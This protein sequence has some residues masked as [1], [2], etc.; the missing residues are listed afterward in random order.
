MSIVKKPF[1]SEFKLELYT[2]SSLCS[3]I[4]TPISTL[5]QQKI[6]DEDW[7][8]ILDLSP[9]PA[10]YDCPSSFADDYLLCSVLKKS[11]N[12]P[13]DIDRK[14]AAV[15]TFMDGEKTCLATNRRL[16]FTRASEFP[17]YIWEIQRFI[18]KVLPKLD[19]KTLDQIQRSFSHGPG[20]TTGV[21]GNG[22]S[23]VDKYEKTMHLTGSLVT[24]TRAVMGD[25]WADFS[26]GKHQIVPG[27]RFTT[28]P[29]SAKTDRGI[30][31]EPTLNM[32]MQ[33]G[34]GRYIRRRLK[35]FGLDLDV[36]SDVN[37]KLAQRAY[38]SFLAT[39]D[40]K[41]AS[42]SISL[43]VVRLLLPPD[44]VE[45]LELVRSPSTKVGSEFYR[46]E[47]HSSMGNG[48]TFELE[49]LIFYACC[50]AVVNP[51]FH[52]DIAVFGDDIIVPQLFSQD[53]IEA[54]IYLGF[55]VNGSKSFL[56]GNFFESCGTDWF[57][58]V[59]VRPF[60]LKGK[61]KGN[62]PYTVQIANKLRVYSKRVS[63]WDG[64][65]SRFR[66]LWTE[67]YRVSP[68]LWRR[69]VV[70]EKFGDTGFI[71]SAEEVPAWKPAKHGIEGKYIRTVSSEKV[72]KQYVTFGV[73][74]DA[75]AGGVDPDLASRGVRVLRG[76]YGRPLLRWTLLTEWS[77][78]F[79][80][81]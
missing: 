20:S 35:R 50:K 48:Y 32:Y 26:S 42:D 41:A 46:L 45:L 51:S 33:K 10:E 21:R 68:S 12:I 6:A 17:K 70:P 18:A 75:L 4:N 69:C 65:D 80:W 43:E 73:L 29:K 31:I 72:T 23:V 28:V 54:L 81:E 19:R 8:G 38:S 53:L 13:L 58:G 67:L 76:K 25:N 78:G 52:A 30:C 77:N 66:P 47:K 36:Q 39:I 74:L 3:I 71:G 1:S 64:C 16:S 27:S 40:L 62:I 49:S 57:K 24:Y 63:G 55:S 15:T 44:W 5:I 34:I 59:N 60:Y 56:A 7:M 22:G 11:P 14:Q 79:E 9:N 2:L 61:A 37:R